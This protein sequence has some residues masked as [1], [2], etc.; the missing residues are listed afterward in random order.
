M[1][2]NKPAS[3]LANYTHN[4]PIAHLQVFLWVL[5]YEYFFL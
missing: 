1:L 2:L 4:D 3:Q 5:I